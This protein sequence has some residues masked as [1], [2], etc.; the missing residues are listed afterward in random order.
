MCL[1]YMHGH[2]T[3]VL[4][5][6]FLSVNTSTTA[7]HKLKQTQRHG[8]YKFCAAMLANHHG[9]QTKMP[10]AS[11]LADHA[12]QP[13]LPGRRLREKSINWMFELNDPAGF[14]K[15]YRIEC[16]NWIAHNWDS[17]LSRMLHHKGSLQ[18]IPRWWFPSPPTQTQ[19]PDGLW[20]LV[21]I[22]SFIAG[23]SNSWNWLV[24]VRVDAT[25]TPDSGLIEG[26]EC[27]T[28]SFEDW[29][30][31]PL[32]VSPLNSQSHECEIK[33]FDLQ[34]VILIWRLRNWI[35]DD[36]AITIREPNC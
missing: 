25:T 23:R 15:N 18:R 16:S 6:Q 30:Q 34:A 35:A 26:L 21:A 10:N 29:G 14:E 28:F 27:S 20:C 4:L 17:T 22:L 8:N 11:M 5:R 3:S 12:C 19:L 32:P 2:P 33:T 13:L 36:R 24:P 1:N 9:S 31:I 7:K